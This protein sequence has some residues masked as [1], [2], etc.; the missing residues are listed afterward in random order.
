MEKLLPVVDL[1]K[2]S[3]D[4][5]YKKFWT[6]AGLILFTFLG[7]LAFLPLGLIGLAI[8]WGP[9]SRADY[10]ATIILV[11]ILLGLLG[12]FFAILFGLW[13]RV[14]SFFSIKEQ[15]LDFKSSLAVSWPKM[16]Q[17]F[18][19]SLLVG[20]AVLGGFILF[21]IPGVIFSVW[22]CLAMFVFVAEGLEG[23]SALKRS[24]QL[25]QGYWWPV[26]GRLALLGILI[27]LISSIKFFGPIINV[28][29]MAPFGIAFEYYLYED[30]RRVKG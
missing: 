7:L 10:N 30:L 4:L 22:F 29:F 25:V 17:F 19:V 16:W 24:K 15:E 6:L 8:S 20:L 12:L 9:F 5:Y 14:A 18:W 27:M 26:F 23:T 11:D 3:F 21:V 2:K 28:F 13:S 1:I